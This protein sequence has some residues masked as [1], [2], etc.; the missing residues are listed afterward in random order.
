MAGLAWIV[1][2]DLTLADST[3][4][5]ASLTNE[6]VSKPFRVTNGGAML[7]VDILVSGVTVGGGITAKLQDS[8]DGY[9]TTNLKKTVAVTANGTV[10]ITLLAENSSDQTHL[11]LRNSCRV[12]FDTGAGSAVT[13]DQI[14]VV[15]QN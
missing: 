14:R 4:L 6:V 3:T 12:V 10:T 7:V 8:S 11:P 5:G 15:Q 13:I 1:S 2:D 9:T